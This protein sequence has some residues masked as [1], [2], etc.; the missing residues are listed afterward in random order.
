MRLFHDSPKNYVFFGFFIY[1]FAL[2]ALFPRLADLQTQMDIS[3]AALGLALVGLP[4]GV[5]ITLLFADRLV[6]QIPLRLLMG[7]GIPVIGLSQ[8]LAGLATSPV[9]FF[10]CLML[11][12]SAVAVIEVAVN[13]E[14]DR[15]EAKTGTRIMN[16]SHA[17]WSFGFFT[18]SM[19][20]AAFAQFAISPFVNFVI[21]TVLATLASNLVF[22]K[23][24]PA[25]RRHKGTP[26][27]AS[28]VVLPS[29]AVSM[30]VLF[31]LSAMLVEG[32]SIDW[33]IIF[34]RDEFDT[35]PLVEGLALVCAALSQAVV[36]YFADPLVER[37]GPRSVATAS[38]VG[39][40]IGVILVSCSMSPAMA[41]VGFLFMGG[42]SAV[43]FPLAMSAA[44]GRDDRPSEE[45]VAALAQFAFATFL[46]A[47]PLLG[48]I[49]EHYGL[50]V[51][52]AVALPFILLSFLKRTV[53]A[54]TSPSEA[55]KTG[56]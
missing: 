8:C 54:K 21:V 28:L 56:T 4:V 13:L 7:L 24:T 14:A 38:V 50:R 15:V 33:S 5:Q 19:V 29:Y 51:A 40:G 31:S 20:G 11:G 26:E 22:S 18:A 39:M 2:G 49:S 3:K 32:S 52:F 25:E 17:Y 36:R 44:A 9:P 35:L 23:Y 53:M 1:A 10:I 46:I 6:R 30:L 27:K 48:I 41:L 45:N 16:R 34:M 55:D 42:G 43:I 12:G 47:P 37:F